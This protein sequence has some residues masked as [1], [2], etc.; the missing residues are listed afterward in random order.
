MGKV[1]QKIP[2]FFS[3]ISIGIIWKI[4]GSVWVVVLG[5]F[6]IIAAAEKLQSNEKEK[7]RMLIYVF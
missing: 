4:Y 3:G 7:P 5:F 1:L 6:C 2:A